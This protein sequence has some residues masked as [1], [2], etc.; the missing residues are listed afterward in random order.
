MDFTGKVAL[1]TGGG[2][3]IGQA[4]ALGFAKHG[5]RVVIVDIDETAGLAGARLVKERGGDATFVRADAARAADDDC[6][7]AIENFH[8]CL[9]LG[10]P[11]GRR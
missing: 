2:G 10:L 7:L 6:D 8:L 11:R 5:A 4:A 3:D 1:I 9:L